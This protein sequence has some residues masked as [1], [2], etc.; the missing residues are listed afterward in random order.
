MQILFANSGVLGRQSQNSD[1]EVCDKAISRGSATGLEIQT[2]ENTDFAN[3]RCVVILRVLRSCSLFCTGLVSLRATCL[4][5]FTWHTHAWH[6]NRFNQEHRLML[7]G[8]STYSHFTRCTLYTF[9]WG[10]RWWIRFWFD[11][12]VYFRM[13]KFDPFPTLTGALPVESHLCRVRPTRQRIVPRHIRQLEH[14]Q[15]L[16][17]S[18][19]QDVQ[20]HSCVACSCAIAS[21]PKFFMELKNL[22]KSSKKL[23]KHFQQLYSGQ[24]RESS[25]LCSQFNS[26]CS[27]SHDSTFEHLRI[28]DSRCTSDCNWT[29]KKSNCLWLPW[30]Y[31]TRL[32]PARLKMGLSKKGLVKASYRHEISWNLMKSGP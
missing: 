20:T 6:W 24:S 18:L 5:S 17:Q 8:A 30:R 11:E 10:F 31:L 16:P 12:A 23:S 13:W 25:L 27:N 2:Q 9:V 22:R 1:L 4:P 32:S 15:T 28:Q 29:M 19:N 21:T 7:Q 14:V 26:I 3:G